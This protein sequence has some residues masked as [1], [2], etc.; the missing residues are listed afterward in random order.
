MVNIVT[1]ADGKKYM[2]DVGFGGN[3]PVQ[4]MLL[5]AEHSRTQ[6]IPPAEARLI[7]DNIPENTDPNQKLWIFQHRNDPQSPWLPMYCF[8]E[9]EFLPQDYEIMN[10]QTSQSRN[11]WF[12]YRIAVVK[13]NLEEGE[14]VGTLMLVGADVK[15]RKR[16]ETEH[17]MTCANETERVEALKEWFGIR[18]GEDEKAGIKGMVTELHG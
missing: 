15:R 1:L 4:P 13:M 14:V 16:G 2:L 17:V 10:F 11:S 8:T 3:G 6:N 9:L 7:Y 5:D 12:T 18:L